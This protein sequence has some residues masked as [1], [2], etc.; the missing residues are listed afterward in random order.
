MPDDAIYVY[1]NMTREG[2]TCIFPDQHSAS[3]PN[4]PWKKENNKTKWYSNLR[5]GSKVAKTNFLLKFRNC[6]FLQITYD[7]A[8]MVQMTFLKLLSEEGYQNFTYTCIN[9]VAWFDS[10]TQ[11]FDLSLR[12]RGD[13]GL[14]FSHRS[15]KPFVITDGCK[16]GKGK[17]QTVFEIRTKKVVQLP[18]VDFFPVDYGMPNQAFGFSTG[19]VCFR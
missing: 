15:A 14:E 3:V 12:L 19:P 8:G 11:T 10:K 16:S 5:G 13:N 6:S 1:C 9:S 18:I 17:K 4:I 7:T 2:E